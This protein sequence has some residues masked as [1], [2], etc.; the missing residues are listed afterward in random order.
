MTPSTAPKYEPRMRLLLQPPERV[1]EVGARIH[2]SF[3]VQVPPSADNASGGG[4]VPQL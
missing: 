1:K 4:S 2:A 3:A